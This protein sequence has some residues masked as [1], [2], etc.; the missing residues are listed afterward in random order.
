MTP[1]ALR[2][3]DRAGLPGPMRRVAVSPECQTRRLT[4]N[5]SANGLDFGANLC[6]NESV[7]E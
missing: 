3:N 7:F 6:S 1:W 4:S 5:S 2:S